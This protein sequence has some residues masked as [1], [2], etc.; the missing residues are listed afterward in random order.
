MRPPVCARPSAFLGVIWLAQPPHPGAL[1]GCNRCKRTLEDSVVVAATREECQDCMVRICARLCPRPTLADAHPHLDPTHHELIPF[2]EERG[3]PRVGYGVHY[4]GVPIP[5]PFARD[6][7]GLCPVSHLR[8]ARTPPLLCCCLPDGPAGGLRDD[9][10][11]VRCV[12]LRDAMHAVRHVRYCGRGEGWCCPDGSSATP[13]PVP[14]HTHTHARRPPCAKRGVGRCVPYCCSCR[15][16]LFYCATKQLLDTAR[17]RYA[18]L[19]VGCGAVLAAWPRGY[20]H[21][22]RTGQGVAEGRV[23]CPGVPSPCHSICMPQAHRVRM[24]QLRV[25]RAFALFRCVRP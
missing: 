20:G 16:S 18:S 2:E 12:W 7:F 9:S 17:L 8:G 11:R 14:S 6:C 19:L 3:M 22:L 21:C 13:L 1:P 10:V 23:V 4:G 5:R 15:R 24:C 25:T